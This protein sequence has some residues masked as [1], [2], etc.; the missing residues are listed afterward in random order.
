MERKPAFPNKVKYVS[1][2]SKCV[3]QEFILVE[4]RERFSKYSAEEQLVLF[5]DK[6][7]ENSFIF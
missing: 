6:L 1:G 4:E 5:S 3:S 7:S 2:F